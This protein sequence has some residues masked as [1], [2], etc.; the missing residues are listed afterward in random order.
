MNN[1]TRIW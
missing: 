1:M